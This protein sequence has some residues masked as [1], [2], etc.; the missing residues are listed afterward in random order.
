MAVL[1]FG[2]ELFFT[3]IFALSFITDQSI[4]FF[5]LNASFSAIDCL[6]IS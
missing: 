6:I 2:N 5:D 1:P 3:N 4:S